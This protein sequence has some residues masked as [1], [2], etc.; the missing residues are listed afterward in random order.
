[1]TDIFAVQ[2]DVTTQI[3]AALALNLSSGDRES[4]AVE[5]TDNQEAYDCLLRGRELF[6]R[7]PKT[8]TAKPG[9]CYGAP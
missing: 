4:I 8:P 5:H 7:T 9:T 6:F 2:D 1:M 3:V